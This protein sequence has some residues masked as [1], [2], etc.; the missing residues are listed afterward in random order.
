MRPRSRTIL[1]IALIA[2]AL[3]A[4]SGSILPRVMDAAYP[5]IKAETAAFDASTV[6]DGSYEGSAF[7]LP[8]SV[9]VKVTVAGGRIASIELLRHFN[10]QG[11][12]AEAMPGRVIEAQSLNVDAI[13]GATHSSLVMLEAIRDALSKGAKR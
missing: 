3:L 7:L 8:V 4:A 9:R 11:K 13:S 5:R 10:G 6:T 12:P 1:V 2:F